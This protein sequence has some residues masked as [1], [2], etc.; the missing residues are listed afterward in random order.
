MTFYKKRLVTPQTKKFSFV[1]DDFSGGMDGKK[2]GGISAKNAQICFNTDGAYGAFKQGLGFDQLRE[3]AFV[4][5]PKAKRMQCFCM[6]GQDF[7]AVVDDQDNLAVLSLDN[8]TGWQTIGK[9]K[10]EAKLLPYRQN[11]KVVLLVYDDN[12]MWSWDGAQTTVISNQPVLTDVVL[13]HERV[14]GVD[15]TDN[16]LLRFCTHLDP[17]Q[18]TNDLGQ[19]GYI[20]LDDNFGKV[21]KLVSFDGCVF[22]FGVCKIAKIQASS[23]PDEF[24]VSKLISLNG[25]IQKDSIQP[26]GD[27]IVFLCDDGLYAF[28]GTKV[29]QICTGLSNNF[30]QSQNASCFFNTKYYLSCKMEFFDG[31]RILCE[32]DEH[33]NNVVIEYDLQNQQC[34][35]ARG[36]DVSCL[37]KSKDRLLFVSDQKVGQVSDSGCFFGLSLPKVWETAYGDFDVVAKKVLRSVQLYTLSN[38]VIKIFAD[39]KQHSF[40]FNGKKSLQKQKLGITGHTFKI[41]FETTSPKPFVFKP[42][43]EIGY[44]G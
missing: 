23:S 38:L 9:T 33:Q 29:Q 31:R 40:C 18:W 8:P 2:Y 41:C 11:Q 34:K 15:A 12:G 39:G 22:A 30:V 10:G 43:F 24:F 20:R 6:D 3:N 7:L 25:K 32:A 42:V 37:A 13:C 27:Q 5:V 16:T 21:Q 4:S 35:I 1:F 26:C 36:V 44:G 19:T 17:S 14:F 28:D